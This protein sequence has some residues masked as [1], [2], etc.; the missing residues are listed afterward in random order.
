MLC[1]QNIKKD[2]EDLQ[3]SYNFNMVTIVDNSPKQLGE[4]LF[5]KYSKSQGK[6]SD[7]LV[8]KIMEKLK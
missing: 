4:V 6:L 7:Y 3:I 5:E 2:L 8:D 1:L